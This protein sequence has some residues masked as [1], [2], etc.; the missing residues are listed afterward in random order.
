MSDAL[1][2]AEPAPWTARIAPEPEPM[3]RNELGQLLNLL[4]EAE[5]AGSKLLAGYLDELSP[6]S[7]LFATLREVQRDEARNCAF[8]IH[9]LLELEIEPSTATGEFYRKGLAIPGTRQRLE[10]LNRGQG[11]VAKRIAVALPRVCA[12]EAKAILQAM[13]ESHLS[14]IAACNALFD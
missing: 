5:R 4:L 2:H 9:L 11:W 8:L 14:N 10:F 12:T 13:H 1:R 6:G 7:R 3:L